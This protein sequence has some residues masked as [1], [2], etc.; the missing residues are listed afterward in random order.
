MRFCLVPLGEGAAKPPEARKPSLQ[1]CYQLPLWL[2]MQKRPLERPFMLTLAP[3]QLP[4]SRTL[5]SGRSRCVAV[6]GLLFSRQK[7]G[8][9]C[10]SG[11]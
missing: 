4:G 2:L 10:L 11:P 1:Q 3:L 7:E 5:C 9:K 8:G 6:Q